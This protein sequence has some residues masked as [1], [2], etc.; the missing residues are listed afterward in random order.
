MIGEELLSWLFDVGRV[1]RC[2]C[3]W[4]G[5]NAE[6][7]EEKDEEKMNHFASSIYLYSQFDIV[8]TNPMQA[9]PHEST[10]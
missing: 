4:E 3:V 2:V 1:Q 7:Q 5:C 8:G 6:K 10:T 9:N